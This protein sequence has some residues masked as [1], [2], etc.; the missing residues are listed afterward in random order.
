MKVKYHLPFSNFVVSL[1]AFVALTSLITLS[2]WGDLYSRHLSKHLPVQ[3]II[4]ED[5]ITDRNS[6]GYSYW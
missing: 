2:I 5:W 4:T 3:E 1:N 6:L